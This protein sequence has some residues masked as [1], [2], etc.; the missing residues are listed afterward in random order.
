[1]RTLV[2]KWAAFVTLVISEQTL[3]SMIRSLGQT[4][5]LGDITY[6]L[7]GHAEVRAPEKDFNRDRGMKI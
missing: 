6:F 1:M 3:G 7:P 4:V 2:V 5:S